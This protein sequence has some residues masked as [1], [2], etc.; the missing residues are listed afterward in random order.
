MAGFADAPVIMTASKSLS[1]QA[2][3]AI[4]MLQP[5]RIV[6]CGGPKAVS[7]KVES[8]AK[9]AAGAGA[10]VVRLQGSTADETAV[11]VYRRGYAAAT[12]DGYEEL[13]RPAQTAAA[14]S[15]NAG[16]NSANID[17]GLS[18]AANTNL[19]LGTA[20]ADLGLNGTADDSYAQAAKVW[21]NTAFICTDNGYWDAL[22]VASVAYAKHSPIFLTRNGG[23]AVSQSTI[24][25]LKGH[26][27]HIYVIGGSAAVSDKVIAQVLAAG[28]KV[29]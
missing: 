6:I 25:A 18:G 20:N 10:V 28:V 1:S 15:A 19:A 14:G 13:S 24:Q 8:E 4:Q 29:E 21:S 16:L 12:G 2:K 17:L 5:K 23:A 7:A 22:S 26:F 27:K 11:D 3:S 9:Q